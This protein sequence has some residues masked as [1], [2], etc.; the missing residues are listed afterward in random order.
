MVAGQIQIA[1]VKQ[2]LQAIE[3]QGRNALAL[4]QS[5]TP[6]QSPGAP[7]NVAAGVGAHVNVVA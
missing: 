3:Q 4:I 1:V 5:A 6:A 7:A 2:Q